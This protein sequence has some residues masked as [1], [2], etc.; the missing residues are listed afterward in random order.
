MTVES[1]AGSSTSGKPDGPLRGW[2]L[3]LVAAAIYTAG[4]AVTWVLTDYSYIDEIAQLV[5]QC[6]PYLAILVV[7]MLLLIRFTRTRVQGTGWPWH[8]VAWVG[9]ILMA[10]GISQVVLTPL[11][12]GTSGTDFGLLAAVF[13]GTMLVGLGEEAA[14][15][16]LVLNGLG[17]VVRT[18]VAVLVSSVLFGLLHSV[19]VLAD[20]P[21]ASMVVQ[22]ILTTFVGLALGWIYIF[23]NRNLVLVAVLHG[24]WDFAVIGN[25]LFPEPLAL[26]L[27]AS[28]MLTGF[29]VMAT[30]FGWR[31]FRDVP[32]AEI[33]SR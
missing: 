2:A 20:V 5:R 9:S 28:P 33:G 26:T 15:R 13:V 10:I 3:A 31:K 4:M 19:N 17:Q 24:L 22:V 16:G 25:G 27:I 1:P 14:Y 11:V 18:P 32:V 12:G 30:Y 29:A 6:I 7:L 21:V 8:P 23:S